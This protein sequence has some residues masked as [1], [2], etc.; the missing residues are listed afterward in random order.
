[1]CRQAI[2]CID[3]F[4]IRVFDILTVLTHIP[5]KR[6]TTNLHN[7][8]AYSGD[9]GGPIFSINPD[10]LVGITSFGAIRCAGLFPGK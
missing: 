9:S 6:V 7:I 3:A 8:C 10:V 4:K 5:L 2:H 1:M